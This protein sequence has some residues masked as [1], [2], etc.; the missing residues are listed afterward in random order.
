MTWLNMAE[1]RDV[2]GN[3]TDLALALNAISDIGCD[4]GTDEDESCVCCLCE[5]ALKCLWEQLESA[6]AE[7]ERLKAELR[8][9]VKRG[10]F[11]QGELTSAKGEVVSLKYGHTWQQERAAVVAWLRH[12]DRWNDGF[13]RS[14]S[15]Y[16]THIERDAHWTEGKTL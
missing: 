8:E 16:A 4:C 13:T 6:K 15:Y 1:Q 11:I 2:D 7:V 12:P 5:Q 9:A 3:L 10:D 14:A